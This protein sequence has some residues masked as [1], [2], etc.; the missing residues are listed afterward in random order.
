MSLEVELMVAVLGKAA[1]HGE[2]GAAGALYLKT[3]SKT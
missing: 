3:M 1:E 2:N